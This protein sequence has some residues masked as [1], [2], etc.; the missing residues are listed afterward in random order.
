MEIEGDFA[1]AVAFC[2]AAIF[3]SCITFLCGHINSKREAAERPSR[4]MVHFCLGV[5]IRVPAASACQMRDGPLIN[6]DSIRK[7]YKYVCVRTC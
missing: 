1:A 7:K 2:Q 3:S 4:R 5:Y 6:E